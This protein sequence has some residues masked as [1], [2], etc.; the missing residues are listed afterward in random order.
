M[1]ADVALLGDDLETVESLLP[2]ENEEEGEDTTSRIHL[3]ES[4][5][6]KLN[7]CETGEQIFYEFFVENI[8]HHL[9]PRFSKHIYYK[10][11]IYG[12]LC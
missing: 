5:Q 12:Q 8:C 2:E 9:K 4:L 7:K 3:L 1:D 11:K 10:F 6:E